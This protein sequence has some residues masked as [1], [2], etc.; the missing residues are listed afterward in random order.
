MPPENIIRIKSFSDFSRGYRNGIVV[1][2]WLENWL[3]S[4]VAHVGRSSHVLKNPANFTG[5]HLRWR[6]SNTSAFL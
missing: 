4:N 1:K 5:K 6:N 2:W 3:K